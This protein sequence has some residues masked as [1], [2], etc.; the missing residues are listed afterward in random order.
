MAELTNVCGLQK[1]M[2]V[3]KGFVDVAEIFLHN[4]VMGHRGRGFLDRLSDKQFY[5][6]TRRVMLALGAVYIAQ[7][8]W[9]MVVG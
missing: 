9:Q 8:L 6:W 1:G 7:G 3:D 5:Y 2:D 4:V